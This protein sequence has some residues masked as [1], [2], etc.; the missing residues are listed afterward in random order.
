MSDDSMTPRSEDHDSDEFSPVATDVERASHPSLQWR[1][2]KTTLPWQKVLVVMVSILLVWLLLDAVTLKHNAEV[3]P[4]GTRRTV[5]LTILRPIAA[6]SS[7]LQIA[8]IEKLANKALGR[9]A[10]GATTS[11][12]LITVGP[13]A[14]V[15]KKPSSK[16]ATSVTTTTLNPLTHATAAA[17]VRILLIGDS[18][19]LDLGGSLQNS[20]ASTGIVTATLDGKESTGLTRPDY[21]NWPA[22]LQSDLTKLSP[23]VIVVMMGAN[24]PQ[25]FPG[26]PDVPFGTPAWNTLYQQRCV[27]F[28]QLAVSQGAKLVWV[29]L[30]GMQ[31][32]TLN[33]KIATVNS[34]QKA[35]AAQVPG[36]VYVDSS[37]V[38]GNPQGGFSAF[39][40]VN[41]Q[42]I[43]VRTPDGIHIT[44]QG[45]ALLATYVMNQMKSQYGIPFP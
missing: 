9:Q 42:A 39:T 8:D 21:F 38:L 29:S 7:A 2:G 30:P 14:K 19:G 15:T 17:P 27:A 5:A 1:Q 6:V 31:N 13:R 25:D 23:Q 45:G 10:D 37:P 24:D 33:A 36:V 16:T 35:A 22:E 12:A 11:Q 34:L 3:S 43:H 32:P 18:L 4:V 28:M 44:P 40:T 20:L 26:P 41:G